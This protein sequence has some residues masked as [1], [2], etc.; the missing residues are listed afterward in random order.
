MTD[1]FGVQAVRDGA[2]GGVPATSHACSGPS[3]A[4]EPSVAP[5]QAVSYQGKLKGLAGWCASFLPL[6]PSPP[7]QQHPL[8]QA[9]TCPCSATCLPAVQLKG[10]DKKATL[11]AKCLIDFISFHLPKVP[12]S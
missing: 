7:L 5:L 2:R 4:V 9:D 10:E 3:P 12:M 8:T 1:T 11:R 6:P